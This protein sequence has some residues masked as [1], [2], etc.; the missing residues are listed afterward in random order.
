MAALLAALVAIGL[1]AWTYGRACASLSSRRRFAGSAA[2]VALVTV[3]LMAGLSQAGATAPSP[4]AGAWEAWSEKRV[5][6]LRAAGR[7][8]F[9]DFT[10]DWCLT[11]QV[12]DRVALRDPEVQDRLREEGVVVLKADW[13]RHDPRITE[14]LAS[15]GRQGV[16]LYVLY[17]ATADQA[18]I[19]LPEVITPGIVLD[20]LSRA[21]ESGPAGHP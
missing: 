7:P 13:T 16:P 3:G 17:G 4:G 6:D 11:C 5:A 20:A 19:V 14:A 18:A 9:V 8:V 10:A 2:A 1:G 15:H 21:R 12:N